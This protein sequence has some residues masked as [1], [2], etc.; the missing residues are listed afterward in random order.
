MN[1]KAISMYNKSLNNF[2]LS[3]KQYPVKHKTTAINK[4]AWQGWHEYNVFKQML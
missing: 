4:V 3:K 2:M 1:I